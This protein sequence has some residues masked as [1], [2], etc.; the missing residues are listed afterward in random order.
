MHKLCLAAK[1]FVLVQ[2]INLRLLIFCDCNCKFNFPPLV[3][4]P[5]LV[6][7]NRIQLAFS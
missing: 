4:S 3:I 6:N 7:S 5:L 2:A 1:R